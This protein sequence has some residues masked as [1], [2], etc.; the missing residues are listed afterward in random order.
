MHCMTVND[1]IAILTYT[2][3]QSHLPWW[4]GGLAGNI[5][6]VR[7]WVI[8]P[9]F[10]KNI[11]TILFHNFLKV[12]VHLDIRDVRI[13]TK[14]KKH[15]A[16]TPTQCILENQT[17]CHR[18]LSFSFQIC[19]YAEFR[20]KACVALRHLLG[21]LQKFPFLWWLFYKDKLKTKTKKYP[22]ESSNTVAH[23]CILL[24]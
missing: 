16:F 6:A 1:Y 18:H 24:S 14:K 12:F 3:R 15:I 4:R 9:S 20:V 5:C 13:N 23:I 10:F 7:L 11:V 22:V 17:C 21:L 8:Y 19:K 2:G